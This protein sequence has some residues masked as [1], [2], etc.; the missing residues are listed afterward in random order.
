MQREIF[1]IIKFSQM[2]IQVGPTGCEKKWW[3]KVKSSGSVKQQIL[4]GISEPEGGPD[5]RNTGLHSPSPVRLQLISTTRL[6]VLTVEVS[7]DTDRNI[8]N[9]ET[10]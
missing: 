9:D 5:Q 2:G 8:S 10:S 1:V 6:L 7:S 3:R 4:M